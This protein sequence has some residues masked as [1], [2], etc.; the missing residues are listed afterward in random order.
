MSWLK[1][2]ML[3]VAAIMLFGVTTEARAEHVDWSSYID[4]D[5]KVP[6]S[7]TPTVASASDDDAAVPAKKAKKSVASKSKSKKTKAKAKARAR[8]KARRK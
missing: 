8:T 2:S 5:S 6:A 4:H 3:V 1:S 7:R